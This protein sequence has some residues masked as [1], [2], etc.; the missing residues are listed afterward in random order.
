VTVDPVDPGGA[1]G[2]DV[3]HEEDITRINLNR[4][5]K[6]NAIDAALVEG[7]LA[8]LRQAVRRRSRL[9]VFSGSGRAFSAGFDLSD[10]DAQSDG[11]LVLRFI[12]IETLLQ[13][14]VAAPMMTLALAHGRCIGAGADIFNV[15]AYRVAASDTTFRMPGLKFGMLLGARRFARLVGTDT[16]RNI[17]ATSRIFEVEEG[18]RIGFVQ[19]CAER[20]TWPGIIEH[21]LKEAKELSMDAQRRMLR[22]TLEESLDRDMAELVRSAAEPGLADRIRH[23]VGKTS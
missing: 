9:V 20:E 7:M 2:V 13:E 10:M 18:L 16:A 22:N 4:P 5:E 17:L 1:P 11:Q 12:R 6:L 15:C 23:F 3:A 14:I 21:N 8:G 19:Q